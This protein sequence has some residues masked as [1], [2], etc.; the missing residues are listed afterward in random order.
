MNGRISQNDL[1]Y[2]EKQS[3]LS[4]ELKYVEQSKMVNLV[5]RR[6]NFEGLDSILD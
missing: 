5:S 1:G 6:S 3:P 2:F 4:N